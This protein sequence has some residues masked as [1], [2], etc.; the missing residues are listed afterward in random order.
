MVAPVR[1]CLPFIQWLLLAVGCW[2]IVAVAPLRSAEGER[3]TGDDA[4]GQPP[5]VADEPPPH[6]PSA[7]GLPARRMLT[8][9]FGML[10]AI[11]I[12][13]TLLLALVVLWGNRARRLAR[14]PLP[15]VSKQDDLWFL[16]P[17]KSLDPAEGEPRGNAEPGETAGDSG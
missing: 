6:S 12:G 5:A 16:K 2:L 8:F 4:A 3:E 15:P 17:K 14:S 13:G 7:E 11:L 1:S 10:A 9:A